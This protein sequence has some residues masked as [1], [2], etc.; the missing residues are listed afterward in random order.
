VFPTLNL[1]AEQELLPAQ[2][3]YATETVLEGAVYPS[4]TNVGVRPTFNGNGLSIESHLLG[5]SGER[6]S[7]PLEVR[8]R[9]RLR[10]EQR[11]ANADSLR[12]Q[13]GID[14][15]NAKVFFASSP[16]RG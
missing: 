16:Q 15:E 14:I 3:V 2:G 12:A 7:G 1:A 5:Y 4:V 11:F 9:K 6:K 8:F 13:I 10:A